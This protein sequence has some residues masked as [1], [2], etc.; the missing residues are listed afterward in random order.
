MSE[1]KVGTVV[2]L[3]NGATCKVKKELGKG[4]QG[5]VYVAD[6]D[7]NDMALTWY[8]NDSY[9]DSLRKKIY[10]GSPSSYFL[11]PQYITEVDNGCFC[12][13]TD[14]RPKGY[15]DLSLFFIAKQRFSSFYA[16]TTAAMEICEALKELHAKGFCYHSFSDGNIFIEPSTG[17]VKICSD[18][19][20][21]CE[22]QTH[23]LGNAR[24][25]APEI[26][27]G[28]TLPNGYSDRFTMSVILFMLFYGNHPFE[29]A[30]Y[31]SCPL[32]NNPEMA[33]NL[34]G[35][36]SV[37]IMDPSDTKNRPVRG[38]HNNVIKR[39]PL[40]PAILRDAFTNEFSKDKLQNPEKRF[41]E[42]QWIDTITEVRNVLVR[43]P[44]CGMETFVD[45]GIDDNKCISCG[46]VI[47]VQN[48]K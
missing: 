40:L 37:F 45:K 32:D 15:Y 3:T 43:C 38:L 8:S 29:G 7:G 11:W 2:S 17:H 5:I 30:W 25:M 39:W 19:I 6:L 34:F 20:F 21:Q 47:N 18:D 41:T 44:H 24:Y 35:F 9:Y 13:V 46:K 28:K 10:A 33:K 26:V 1:L 42:Q 16:V 23:I 36:S 48:I 22:E 4:G 12:C 14:L 31:L 27:A